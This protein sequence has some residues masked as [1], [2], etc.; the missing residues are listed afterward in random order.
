[1]LLCALLTVSLLCRM[2]VFMLSTIIGP[3]IGGAFTSEVSWR[4]CFWINLPVG[5]PIIILVFLFLRIPKHIKTEP[6]TRIQLLRHFDLPGFALLTASL[7]CLSLALQQGGL[8][9]PWS[10]GSVVTSLVM[11]IVLTIAFF[12]AEWFQGEYAMVTLRLL[13]PRMTWANMLY[14]IV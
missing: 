2:S 14:G 11:W 12:V 13:K 7:V 1:M 5:G 10:A 3:L 4:W 6:T 8:T 9:H